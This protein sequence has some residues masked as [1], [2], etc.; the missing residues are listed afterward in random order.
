[1]RCLK[2]RS[3]QRFKETHSDTI[4]FFENGVFRKLIIPRPEPTVKTTILTASELKNIQQNAF[5][6]SPELRKIKEDERKKFR[7]A[8]EKAVENRKCCMKYY[9]DV[10]EKNRNS[11]DTEAKNLSD[12]LNKRAEKTKIEREEEVKYLNQLIQNVKC[13]AIR[14]KQVYEKAQI[15][16]EIKN[17][18]Q[19]LDEM[20]ERERML[21][22]QKQEEKDKKNKEESQRYGILLRKQIYDNLEQKELDKDQKYLEHKELRHLVKKMQL[23]DLKAFQNQKKNQRELMADIL[24]QLEDLLA[25]RK[26]ENERKLTEELRYLSFMNEKAEREEAEERRRREEKRQ[27]ERQIDELRKKQEQVVDILAEEDERKA[28][29][30][31]EE[32]ERKW[33]KR[34]LEEAKKSTQ[35]KIELRKALDNQVDTKMSLLASEKQ[36]DK[37]EFH[38]VL[39]HLVSAL[40]NERKEEVS[41]KKEAIKYGS[42]LLAQIRD[43]EKRYAAIR[44]AML[45]RGETNV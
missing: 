34:E 39:Y 11:N 29:R 37:E 22:I 20:M 8:L 3:P 7:D 12:L 17:V 19:S 2:R 38:R 32:R 5:Y 4:N 33:R 1:M 36:K 16:K 6:I 14:D 15:E 9:D 28:R 41:R 10:R 30:A 13:Q 44:R 21:A 26:W 23:E 40:E 45:S 31:Q 18:N 24:M 42:D 25:R 35:G 27:R 43:N